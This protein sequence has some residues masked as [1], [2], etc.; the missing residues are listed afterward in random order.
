MGNP[1]IL[2]NN[3][4]VAPKSGTKDITEVDIETFEFTWRANCGSA[5]LMTQLC[6]PAM[7]QKGWGRVIFCSSVAGLNGGVIGPHYA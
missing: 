3:A 5:F 1:T 2:Y 4:G 7:K 6:V